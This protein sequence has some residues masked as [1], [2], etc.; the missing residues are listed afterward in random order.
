VKAHPWL[1]SLSGFPDAY[2]FR[3]FQSHPR[4]CA[5]CESGTVAARLDRSSTPRLIGSIISVSGILDHPLS[6]DD[7]EAISRRDVREVLL[8][9]L[10]L[11]NQN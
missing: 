3:R 8:E 7:K 9:A 5:S 4:R 10:L 6:G 1:I 11:R 2:R